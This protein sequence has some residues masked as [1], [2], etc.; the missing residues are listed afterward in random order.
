[1]F[2]PN[3]PKEAQRFFESKVDFTTGPVEVD[4]GIRSGE[5]FNLVDVR[6]KKDFEEGHVPGAISLPEDEWVSLRGLARDRLNVLYCYSQVCHLAARAAAR[7]AAAGFPVMEMEGGFEAWQEHDLQIERG[8]QK[9]DLREE[10]KGGYRA[11]N[12]DI[13]RNYDAN[14]DTNV[15]SFA[16]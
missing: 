7:F 11:S 2:E 3:R 1:M 5:N 10:K 16:P 8:D 14:T 4:H 6:A 12:P 9:L 15:N 13:A